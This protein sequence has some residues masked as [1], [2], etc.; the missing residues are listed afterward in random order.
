MTSKIPNTQ[1]LDD[2][3]LNPYTNRLIKKNSKTHKK[4]VAAKL[5]DD[6]PS[7]PEEN[8]IIE[9]ETK[10]EA[11][12]IQ[13]KLNKTL[14]KN[15]IITR[16]GTKV[17]KASRRPT[18]QETIEK[19]SDYAVQSVIENKDELIDQDMTDAE[20]DTYIRN[21]IQKKLVGL[22]TTPAPRSTPVSTKRKVIRTKSLPEDDDFLGNYE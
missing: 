18:R 20:M 17:L 5:L 6:I 19:V 8:V 7:T 2:Y 13:G 4:L 14:Q 9:A 11:K 22:D 1:S 10:D 21:L 16:R 3:V 15:K 12:C